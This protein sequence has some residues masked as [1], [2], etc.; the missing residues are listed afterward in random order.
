[1]QKIVPTKQRNHWNPMLDWRTST[2]QGNVAED[3]KVEQWLVD[4]LQ[5]MQIMESA[6]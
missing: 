4:P 2:I 1:M 6:G 5:F 3:Q